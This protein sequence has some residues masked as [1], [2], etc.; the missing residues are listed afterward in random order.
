MGGLPSS[1]TAVPGAQGSSFS[2]SL[3]TLLGVWRWVLPL[4]E[5]RR[6]SPLHPLCSS[7]WPSPPSS[8]SWGIPTNRSSSSSRARSPTRR[9]CS[10]GGGAQARARLG[11]AAGSASPVA[12]I[13]GFRPSTSL[14]TAAQ[15]R[16][17]CSFVLILLSSRFTRVELGGIFGE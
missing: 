13:L 8:P 6:S 1:R 2:G 7:S 16:G 10:P 4:S 15:V 3:D 17:A 11:T 12:L 5:H 14:G 9:G